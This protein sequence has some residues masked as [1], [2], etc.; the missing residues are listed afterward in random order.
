MALTAKNKKILARV[1]KTIGYLAFVSLFVGFSLIL[2]WFKYDRNLTELLNISSDKDIYAL[3]TSV[4]SA[5]SVSSLLWLAIF[6]IM[7]LLKR[8]K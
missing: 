2:L 4:V 1:F 6:R 8:K 7:K 5:I 3:I